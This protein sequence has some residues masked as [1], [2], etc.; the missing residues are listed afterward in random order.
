[1]KPATIAGPEFEAT[2]CSAT[3]ELDADVGMFLFGIM[4]IQLLCS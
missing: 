4:M 1:M 2:A 3:L